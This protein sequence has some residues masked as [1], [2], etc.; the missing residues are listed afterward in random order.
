MTT[1]IDNRRCARLCVR[2]LL[3]D[4]DLDISGGRL[5]SRSLEESVLAA[6]AGPLPSDLHQAVEDLGLP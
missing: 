2:F 3:R 6:Q 1:A 5:V 4:P